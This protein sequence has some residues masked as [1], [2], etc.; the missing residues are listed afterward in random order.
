[1]SAANVKGDTSVKFGITGCTQDKMGVVESITIGNSYETTVEARDVDGEYKSPATVIMRGQK[2]D[3][4]LTGIIKGTDVPKPGDTLSYQK[5]SNMTSAGA[6]TIYVNS[7]DISASVGDFVKVT[8]SG[9]GG[10]DLGT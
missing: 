9:T 1:M 5:G 4:S 2:T 7:V 6:T 8:I 3:V 10:K